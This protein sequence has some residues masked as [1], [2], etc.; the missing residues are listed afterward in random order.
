MLCQITP[1][2]GIMQMKSIIVQ[3]NYP[4]EKTKENEV[5]IKKRKTNMVL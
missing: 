2:M 5:K 4:T 1:K 3:W